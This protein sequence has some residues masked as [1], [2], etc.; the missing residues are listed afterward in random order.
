MWI[1][2][3]VLLLWWLVL[4]SLWL[5]IVNIN[6]SDYSIRILPYLTNFGHDHSSIEILQNTTL[7]IPEAVNFSF[8]VSTLN[9][10]GANQRLYIMHTATSR[11]NTRGPAR[12]ILVIWIG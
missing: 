1:L 8:S 9:I 12:P 4:G 11:R 10:L 2:V 6:Y 5:P 3:G 7:L